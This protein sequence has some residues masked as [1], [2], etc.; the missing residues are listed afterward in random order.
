MERERE[1]N[2]ERGGGGKRE[3]GRRGRRVKERKKE[4]AGWRE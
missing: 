3:V 1:G 4:K 2:G